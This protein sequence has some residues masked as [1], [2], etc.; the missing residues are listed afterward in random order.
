MNVLTKNIENRNQVE[1]VFCSFLRVDYDI[2]RFFFPGGVRAL[3]GHD[4]NGEKIGLA[5]VLDPVGV[6]AKLTVV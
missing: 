6:V 1:F 2:E 4:V 3:A 5:V